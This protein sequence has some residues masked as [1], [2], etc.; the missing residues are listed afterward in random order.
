MKA[1]G[2]H[3]RIESIGMVTAAPPQH[4][5]PSNGHDNLKSV[6]KA[7]AGLRQASRGRSRVAGAMEDVDAYAT[8]RR[9]EDQFNADPVDLRI[10]CLLIRPQNRP[11]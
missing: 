11:I 5:V 3:R 10:V 9:C 8:A 7:S 2:E 6:E 1:N 4:H